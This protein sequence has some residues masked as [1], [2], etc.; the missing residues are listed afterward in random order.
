MRTS[1]SSNDQ[2][3][4]IWASGS[5]ANGHSKHMFFV[6]NV[7]YS[8]GYHYTIATFHRKEGIVLLNNDSYGPTTGGHISAVKSAIPKKNEVIC[9]PFPDSVE[10]TAE[11]LY[12]NIFEAIDEVL[13]RNRY[14][15]S[16]QKQLDY[17]NR[18]CKIFKIRSLLKSIPN[19]FNQILNVVIDQ[20]SKRLDELQALKLEKLKQEQIEYEK[21]QEIEKTQY[22]IDVQNWINGHNACLNYYWRYKDIYIRRVG[23]RIETTA[24]AEVP[25]KD[26]LLLAKL[27]DS[28]LPRM[29]GKHVGVYEVNNVENGIITIGC[30]ELNIDRARHYLL[31]NLPLTGNDKGPVI[32]GQ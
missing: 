10:K 12:N 19:E 4:H 14:F 5:Q 15:Y 11:Y 22:L 25:L 28:Q 24:G 32:F 7:I 18:F 6:D 23:D 3:S 13:G 27:D 30:H 26:A 1:F 16:P 2:L 20:K 31:D 9:T 29:I 21:L 17:Y 8:Y